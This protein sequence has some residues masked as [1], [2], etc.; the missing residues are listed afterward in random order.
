MNPKSPTGH[1]VVRGNAIGSCRVTLRFDKRGYRSVYVQFD[2][3]Y[4]GVENGAP[5]SPA[6]ASATR[7]PT[8]SV[9]EPVGAPMI[10]PGPFYSPRHLLPPA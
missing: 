7:F 9:A 8:A 10:R 3:T 5:T 4:L 6:T 2:A 1:R